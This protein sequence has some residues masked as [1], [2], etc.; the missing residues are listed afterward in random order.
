MTDRGLSDLPA[1]ERL[2]DDV[3]AAAHRAAA[4]DGAGRR[5][6]RSPHVRRQAPRR[7]RP[8]AQGRQYAGPRGRLAARVAQYA[9]RRRDL[10]RSW[11]R[12]SPRVAALAGLVVL[13]AA[14]ASASATLLALRGAVIPVPR[15][16]P[17]EQTPAPGTSRLAGFSV[18]DP[19][20]GEPRWTMRLAT[21][22]TGLLCSTIGQLV[23]GEFGIVGL[24]GRFRRLSPDAAD[25]CSIVRAGAT[26]LAGARVFDAS[27]PADVRTVVSGVAGDRLRAVTIDVAGRTRSVPVHKGGTFLAALAG[28]PEDLAIVVRLRFAGGRVE[29]HPFGVAPLVLPDP[30]GGR[31]WRISSG[32]VSGD[33]RACVT[34]TPARQRRNPP[35]SPAACGK[36]AEPRR[37]VFFAVRRVTPGSGGRPVSPFGEGAWRDTPPRL[38]VWG[39]AG[40]DVA[41]VDVRGPRGAARTGTFFRPNGAFAYMFGPRVRRGQVVVTVRFRDGRTLVRRASTGLLPPPGVRP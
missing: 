30:D 39:V 12:L 9:A 24:D 6:R 25:A 28:L 22:R 2:G 18:A 3:A 17:P 32:V 15:A 40:A 14:A 5:G 36:L 8:G 33:P 31:A 20:P 21:S 4:A 13:S 27:R 10:G 7:D 37:G 41:S 38:I 16:T 23:G 1:L 35:V 11:R 29:R 26:S 34:L 19:R